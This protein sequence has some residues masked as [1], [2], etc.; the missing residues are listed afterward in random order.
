MG[1]AMPLGM[2]V[3]QM[4]RVMGQAQEPSLSLQ[5]DEELPEPRCARV[6]GRFKADDPITTDVNE[7]W[8]AES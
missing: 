5:Q 4:Q 1:F 7:A 3:E 2:T 6:K 8:E